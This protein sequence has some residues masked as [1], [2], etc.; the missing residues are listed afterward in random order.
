MFAPD[1]G[2]PE[3]PATGSSVGPLSVFMTTHDLC[4]PARAPEFV[5]EQGR[6]MGR[7]SLLHVRPVIHD[8]AADIFVGGH[9]TAIAR[10]ELTFP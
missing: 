6:K 7:R 4:P 5:V 10:G 9:V 2:I 1:Y 8:G 3:D